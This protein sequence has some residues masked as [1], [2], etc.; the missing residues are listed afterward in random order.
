MY[1]EGVPTV[2]PDLLTMGV[3]ILGIC[4]GMQVIANVLGGEVKQA[5]RR[6][7]GRAELQ[8]KTAQ[9]LFKGF[10][11]GESTQV[12]MSH[13]DSL[14]NPPPGF[15]VLGTTEN[16]VAAIGSEERAIWAVQFHPEVAH[17]TRGDEMLRNFLFEIADCSADWIPS[18]IIDHQVRTIQEQVGSA[19][20]ICGLSGGVDSSVAAALVQRAVGDQ[21]TCIFV[22]T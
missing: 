1:D 20:V 11:S 21:L 16:S 6:E 19:Q 13:G 8:I 14:P 3:P 5:E 17:T 22:D 7:Y 2:D 12:W 15:E 10:L 9:G 4:Y 18:N